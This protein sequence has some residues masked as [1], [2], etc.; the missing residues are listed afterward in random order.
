M[1][2]AQQV[3]T[4][5]YPNPQ[6]QRSGVLHELPIPIPNPISA[7]GRGNNANLPANTQAMVD[8][9]MAVSGAQAAYEKLHDILEASPFHYILHW[10]SG[11][12]NSSR[13]PDS[14]NQPNTL[15][16]SVVKVL[17][18]SQQVTQTTY[19]Q[20]L[21]AKIASDVPQ[22]A[23]A[24][25]RLKVVSTAYHKG[26]RELVEHPYSYPYMRI[27]FNNPVD[28]TAQALTA[29]ANKKFEAVR[30][31]FEPTAWEARWDKLAQRLGGN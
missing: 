3:A 12:C 23:Q 29:E 8:Q 28:Y 25:Q 30:R 24:T 20:G 21:Q 9:F 31:F 5:A 22:K 26:L 7:Y 6:T 18:P 15:I 2:L 4:T 19:M 16:L 27:W 10:S 13:Y 11:A 1:R 14:V 17:N